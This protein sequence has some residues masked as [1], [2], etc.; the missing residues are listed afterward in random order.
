MMEKRCN[1][2]IRNAR[3]SDRDAIRAVTLAAYEEYATVVPTPLW[4]EYQRHLLATLDEEGPIERIVAE[5]DGTIVGNVLLYPPTTNAYAGLS[6][7][8]GWPEVRLLAVAPEARRRGVGTA[9]MDECK[10]HAHRMGATVLGLHTMDMMQDAIRMYERM[11]FVRT[12]ERDFSPVEGVL[13][14]GYCRRIDEAP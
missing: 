12:P 3:D 14:K 10:Q 5:R 1:L 9:L 8:V 13:V 6:T 11:G 4:I 7:S 2:H